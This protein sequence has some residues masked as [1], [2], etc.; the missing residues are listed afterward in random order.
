VPFTALSE[1][2]RAVARRL[3]VE[4]PVLMN[5]AVAAAVERAR[6]RV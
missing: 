3:A 4:V 2:E 6:G 5:R 1:I